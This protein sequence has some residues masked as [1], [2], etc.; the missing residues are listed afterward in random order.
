[1]AEARPDVLVLGG[2]YVFLDVTPAM[3]RELEERVAAV[4]ARTKVAVL[5]NHD[6]WTDHTLIEE[7]LDARGARVLVN[8]AV[9][10]PAPHD[11][12]ASSAWMSPGPAAPTARAPSRRRRRARSRS[13]SRTRP[14]DSPSSR[15][16]APACMLCGHTH[17]GQIAL[18]GAP[19]HRPRPARPP[20]AVGAA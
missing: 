19:D 7:A 16:A 12:L 20:L 13:R 2:D 17:G 14:R 11:H 9:H 15:G 10:L 4:P 18:P 6:L 5:G 1:M 3:A 8:D